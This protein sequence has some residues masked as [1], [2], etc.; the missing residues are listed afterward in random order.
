MIFIRVA[1]TIALFLTPHGLSALANGVLR[2]LGL[3]K[4]GSLVQII[5]HYVVGLPVSLTLAFS[6]QWGLIGLWSGP[7][8]AVV[9]SIT[10]ETSYL[11]FKADVWQQAVDKANARN[12]RG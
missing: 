9:F 1:P 2:G 8:A 6:M 3:Q 4:L 5:S 12:R 10:L 11:L 7:I